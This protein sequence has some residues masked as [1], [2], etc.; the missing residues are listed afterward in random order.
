[1]RSWNSLSVE[2]TCPDMPQA[3]GHPRPRG[4]RDRRQGFIN[5]GDCSIAQQRRA[6]GDFYLHSVS[7][8]PQT[9]SRR[10]EPAIDLM[11]HTNR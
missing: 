3:M 9:V 11:S 7:D 1:M 10:L 5:V 8:Y 6:V 2:L 4:S